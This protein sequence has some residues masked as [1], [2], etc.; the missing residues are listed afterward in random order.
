[1]EQGGT[2]NECTSKENG[3]KFAVKI[4]PKTLASHHFHTELTIAEKLRH[5][6]VVALLSLFE[7]ES[8]YYLVMELMEG[9]DLFDKAN[10]LSLLSSLRLSSYIQLLNW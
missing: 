9:G 2:V 7:D 1:V 8:K 10:N 5:P 4:V 6:H 3:K